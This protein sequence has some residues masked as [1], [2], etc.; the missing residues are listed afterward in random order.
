M[1]V[2]GIVFSLYAMRSWV[3]RNIVSLSLCNL[4]VKY[5]RSF[6]QILKV[7]L[8]VNIVNCDAFGKI[9]LVTD[10]TTDISFSH[11]RHMDDWSILF[12]WIESKHLMRSN[13][14]KNDLYVVTSLNKLNFCCREKATRDSARWFMRCNWI[15]VVFSGDVVVFSWIYGQSFYAVIWYAIS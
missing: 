1:I 6:T 10:F 11:H 13:N 3:F 8:Y 9:T 5:Y 12:V 15:I 14:S 2:E 7:I 4:I